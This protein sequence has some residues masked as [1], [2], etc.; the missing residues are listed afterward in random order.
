M[1]CNHNLLE[2]GALTLGLTQ[3]IGHFQAMRKCHG[4][5]A[6]ILSLRGNFQVPFFFIENASTLKPALVQK[7]CN[8]VGMTFLFFFPMAFK[9]CRQGLGG[10]Y[11]IHEGSAHSLS[12]EF[13]HDCVVGGH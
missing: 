8:N 7:W 6:I 1:Q 4:S 5:Q 3:I 12:L 11:Y 13:Q 10:V 2:F 9:S